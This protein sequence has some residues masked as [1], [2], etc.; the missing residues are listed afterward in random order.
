MTRI[1]LQQCVLWVEVYLVQLACSASLLLG[2]IDSMHAEA[3]DWNSDYYSWLLKTTVSVWYFWYFKGKKSK[4]DE[5]KKLEVADDKSAK[6]ASTAKTSTS[7]T[8][9]KTM[10]S[11]KSEDMGE[12]IQQNH[13]AVTQFWVNSFHRLGQFSLSI[14]MEFT[15]DYHGNI[16]W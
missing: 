5:P 16:T 4:D 14:N 3:L 9:S 2:A 7:G 13:E 10:T 8:G 11:A 6:S 12:R 1:S 15:Q